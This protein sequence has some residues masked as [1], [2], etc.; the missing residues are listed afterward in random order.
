MS[1]TRN[2]MVSTLPWLISSGLVAGLSLGIIL[3]QKKPEAP[4]EKV[5]IRKVDV[6]L[7][8]PPPPP[9]PQVEEQQESSDAS[10]AS[11]DL[12][13]LGGGPTLNYSKT[14]KMDTPQVEDIKLPEFKMDALAIQE[15]M[16]LNMPLF[17]VK[18]L[19]QV[20]KVV[21][22]Q[23]FPPPRKI[24][25]KGIRRVE[26]SVELIIDLQGKPYV[27]RIINPVYPEMIEVIR[28]WVASARFTIPKKDGQ[29]VQAIYLYGINFNFAG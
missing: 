24:K 2:I 12:V 8:V 10:E 6:A 29:P 9:P 25:K 4:E 19:D 18:T 14:P 16:Q 27:K 5:T 17:E 26:T 13:G 3:L 28:K 22:Q 21:S 20:P 23:Y 15:S 7:P 11:I 1:H